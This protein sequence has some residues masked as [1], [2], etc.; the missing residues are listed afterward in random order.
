MQNKVP[1]KNPPKEENLTIWPQ[2][3]RLIRCC[4]RHTCF[5]GFQY[6][7]FNRRDDFF[8]AIR[9]ILHKNK[10]AVMQSIHFLKRLAESETTKANFDRVFSHPPVF[11]RRK[12]QIR[13]FFCRAA[14]SGT[15]SPQPFPSGWGITLTQS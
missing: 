14:K 8:S 11:T 13:N 2:V 6:H 15:K 10:H 1:M 9:L 4:G 5:F 3:T 7:F 12:T